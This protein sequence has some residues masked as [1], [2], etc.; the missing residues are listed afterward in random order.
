MDEQLQAKQM[1]H[2]VEAEQSLLGS[3][4]IDSRCITDVIGKVKPEDFYIQQNK[5]IYETIYT[6]FNYSET[7]DP[8]TVL[9]KMREL[10][11]HHE[12]SRDYVKQ[13]MEITPTAANA[14][15]YATIVK[16][17]AMLRGLA[18]A[19]AQQCHSQSQG[20]AATGVAGTDVVI[21]L[22]HLHCHCGIQVIL[23]I[24]GS[25]AAAEVLGEGADLL[26]VDLTAYDD[27]NHVNFL[28]FQMFYL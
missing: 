15:R 17:K 8:V 6:M 23:D 5:E 27:T 25:C 3:I 14:V 19:S 28:L 10:G 24:Y 21:I 13:L 9:D 2:S 1:P 4:L 26:L 12:N 16:E 7:I 11:V 22:T 20:A 18:D